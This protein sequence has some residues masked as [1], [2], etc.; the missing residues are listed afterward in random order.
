MDPA[1]YT[2]TVTATNGTS[3]DTQEITCKLYSLDEN[4][5]Y[6]SISDML[7]TWADGTA[8][9]TP[10]FADGTFSYRVSE[11]GRDYMY[12]SPQ[13]SAAGTQT[14]GIT[15]PG[16]YTITGLATRAGVIGTEEDGTYDDGIIR[17]VSVPRQGSQSGQ[18][19][20][21]LTADQPLPDVAKGT[22][23]IFTAYTN[24]PAPAQYCFWRVDASGEVLVKDWST[25]NTFAWT[26]ARVGEYTIACRARGA[27][28]GSYEATRY[29]DV[30]ITDPVE[31]KAQVS[32]ITI[33][34]TEL[35]AAQARKP[36]LIK[37]SATGASEDLL[38]KFRIYD[39]DMRG[40][41]LQEYSV[42]QNCAW[43]PREAGT[44]TISVLVKNSDSF[45]KYDAI[46]S[47]DIVVD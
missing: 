46:G 1:T 40:F 2:L 44:F 19:I 5:T 6:A 13:Y 30:N 34:N 11:A 20:F 43:T 4:I 32:S 12:V 15:A 37:A 14:Y 47:W 38:Y 36:V 39:A 42:N 16:V 9:I 10:T 28:A 18:F 7:T 3:T 21:T 22:P 17:T 23:I 26:P 41:T 45:G 31:A 8:S 33:N 27:G 24:L 35:A 25:S 29:L